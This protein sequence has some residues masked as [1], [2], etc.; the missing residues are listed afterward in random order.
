MQIKTHP[1]C[2]FVFLGI[3]REQMI[4]LSL[5]FGCDYCD[6]VQG[7]GIKSALKLLSE[8]RGADVLQM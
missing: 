7:I 3:D 8:L 5:L 2:G 1:V 6:G 4:A